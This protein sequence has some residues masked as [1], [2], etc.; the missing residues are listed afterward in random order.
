MENPGLITTKIV[1]KVIL[2]F[3]III[4]YKNVE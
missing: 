4:H 1:Q 2:K 3:N